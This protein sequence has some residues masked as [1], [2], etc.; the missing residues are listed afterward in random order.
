[1][2]C[3]NCLQ[4]ILNSMHKYQPRLHLVRANDVTQLPY[5]Q[6]RTYV[7]K[8]TS[9]IA[10]TAYQNE[11]VSSRFLIAGT[12]WHFINCR[13]HITLLL[14]RIASVV[15]V[16]RAFNA[17]NAAEDWPQSICEGL[18]WPGRWQ[19]GEKVSNFGEPY[20]VVTYGGDVR[21]CCRHKLD[22]RSNAVQRL[23]R[24]TPTRR[25][26]LQLKQFEFCN[27]TLRI[28]RAPAMLLRGH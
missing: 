23:H 8:E 13:M 18:S 10:V 20:Y 9:F 24:V 12:M 19:E 6:F 15:N 3:F 1:M 14:Q 16:V 17:D 2:V 25:D 21:F 22:I 5:S 4:T 11:K 27:R 7:F 28:L 26:R